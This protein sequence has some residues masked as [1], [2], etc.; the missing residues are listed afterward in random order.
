MTRLSGKRVLITGGAQGIGLQL[1]LAFAR[2]GAEL[3]IADLKEETLPQAAAAV[4]AQGAKVA[5]F[6][7]DVTNPSA[8]QSLRE[9]V[10]S[11][12]GPIDVLVNNAGLVFGGAFLDVPLPKHRL[13]YA[14]NVQG[15]VDMTYAFLPDLIARPQSHLVNIASV[16]GFI[17]LPYGSTYASSKWAVIGFSESIRLELAQ[18]GHGNVRVTTVCPSYVNTTLFTGATPPRTT[19]FMQPEDLAERVVRAVERNRTFLLAPKLAHLTPFLAGVLPRWLFD[20]VGR[21]FGVSTSMQSWHGRPAMEPAG[22]AEQDTRR[23]PVGAGQR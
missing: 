17:G 5:T 23:E 13:T 7:V 8:I 22:A 11:E 19:K 4:R 21:W 1:A 9:Q 16:S 2:R 3:V 15:L 14:V 20:R 6:Y 10:H 18:L 12:L